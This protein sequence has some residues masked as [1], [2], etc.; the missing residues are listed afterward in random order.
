MRLIDEV[1]RNKQEYWRKFASQSVVRNFNNVHA[2][3]CTAA[4]ALYRACR[5]PAMIRSS[6]FFLSFHIFGHPK[7]EILYMVDHFDLVHLHPSA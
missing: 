1:G 2:R 3:L 5:V 6:H 4:V 7:H